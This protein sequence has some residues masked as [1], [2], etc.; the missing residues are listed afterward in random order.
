[1]YLQKFA[2]RTLERSDIAAEF[3]SIPQRYVLG[4]SPDAEQMDKWKL[5]ISSMIQIDRDEDGEKPVMGQFQQMTM[6]PLSEQLKMAGA[7][8]A[9]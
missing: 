8:F 5:T 6:A 3:Y 7:N 2:K 1:M 4:M 9:G